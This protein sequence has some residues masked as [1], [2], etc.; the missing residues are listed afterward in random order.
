MTLSMPSAGRRKAYVRGVEVEVR[1]GQVLEAA[2]WQIRARNWTGASAEIDLIIS[3]GECLRF[4]E[5]KH[6]SGSDPTG[7]ES[8]DP[9]KQRRLIRGARAWMSRAHAEAS[10]IAFLVAVVGD[11][12]I[13]WFDDA[14]DA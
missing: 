1:V 7:L 11:R 2:G 13:Q 4:V 14:F 6:R 3:R 9:Q 8:V 10:D 5:V 12:E